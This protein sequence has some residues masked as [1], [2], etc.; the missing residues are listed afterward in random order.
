MAVISQ[1]TLLKCVHHWPASAMGIRDSHLLQEIP[2]EW[3]LTW[4]T[5]GMRGD[6]V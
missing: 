3:E 1:P 5:S 2:R 4:C 6:V